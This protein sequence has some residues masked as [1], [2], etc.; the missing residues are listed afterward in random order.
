MKGRKNR[1]R[2]AEKERE[3]EMALWL[4]SHSLFQL[5]KEISIRGLDVCAEGWALI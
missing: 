4:E 3:R 2:G 5:R 1:E